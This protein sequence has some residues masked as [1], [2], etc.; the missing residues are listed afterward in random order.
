MI[1]FGKCLSWAMFQSSSRTLLAI[2]PSLSSS[3]N[4]RMSSSNFSRC[5]LLA[6]VQLSWKRECKIANRRD[7]ETMDPTRKQSNRCSNCS[8]E[9]SQANF[10][11]RSWTFF[12]IASCLPHEEFQILSRSLRLS[13]CSLMMNRRIFSSFST[14]CGWWRQSRRTMSRT[15]LSWIHCWRETRSMLTFFSRKKRSYS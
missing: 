1:S 4:R 2:R 11:N 9:K 7:G 12:S 14:Y 5:F 10:A 8:G 13:A 6:F 15:W 3:A